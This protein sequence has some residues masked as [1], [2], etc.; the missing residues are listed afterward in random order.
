MNQPILVQIQGKE[1]GDR[2]LL[3]GAWNGRDN[4]TGPWKY[5]FIHNRNTY[6]LLVPFKF[7]SLNGA[8]VPRYV[9][10][11]VRMGGRDMPDEA[12]VPHDVFYNYLKKG[13]IKLPSGMLKIKTSNGSWK[14]VKVVSRKFADEVFRNELKKEKHGLASFKPIVAYAGVRA[15]FWKDI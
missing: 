9:K 5:D 15:A 4:L 11:I 12:W 13:K 14:E 2:W 10:P 7:K 6:Q 1:S 3:T 8:S